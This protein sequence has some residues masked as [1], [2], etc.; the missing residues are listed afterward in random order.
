MGL[1]KIVDS[2]ISGTKNVVHATTDF[3]GITA[4][5]GKSRY[6]YPLYKFFFWFLFYVAISLASAL[7]LAPLA[8]YLYSRKR[9][10]HTYYDNK[11]LRFDGTID[12]AYA[13]S[14]QGFLLIIIILTLVD[15]LQQT[16]LIDWLKEQVPDYAVGLITTGINA[17]PTVLVSSFF[18]NSLYKWAQKNTYFCYKQEGSYM[19]RKIL[20]GILVALTGK[21]LALVS[22][23][24]ATP[25]TI[26]IKQRFL[27]RRK[28]FSYS[29]MDFK[30]TIGS[31]YKWFIWR[32]YILIG[33]LFI[34]YPIYLNR[35]YKWT[36]HNTEC[37]K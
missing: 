14:I 3:V 17:L 8:Y 21:L 35:I 34:Y 16:F 28:V 4:N 6:D 9:V 23:G 30:G 31:S 10:E 20:K 25:L 36:V 18:F 32:Y 27:T 15:K 13:V 12:G 5:L 24:L 26:W 22:F 11:K 33:S 1:K 37:R 2:T 7:T 29:Q 19:E